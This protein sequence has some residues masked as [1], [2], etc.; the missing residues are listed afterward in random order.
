MIQNII[1]DDDGCTA[2]EFD[3][4]GIE[5]LIKGLE[6]LYQDDTPGATYVTP[7]FWY[8]HAPWWRF[9]NRKPTM[10]S[11]EFRLRRVG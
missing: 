7:A 10:I 9:W 8:Q 3:D 5:Y 4:E 1:E 2:L 11:G 6:A